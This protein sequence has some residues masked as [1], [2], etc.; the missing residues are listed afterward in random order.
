MEKALSSLP[1]YENPP[2]S[3]VV[4][5][6]QFKELAKLQVPHIG[7]FWERIGRVEFPE[8]QE[9]PPLPHIVEDYDKLPHRSAI[10]SIEKFDRPPLPRIFFISKEKNRLIQVQ[11][12]RLLQN[13]RKLE[14]GAEYPRY[15]CLFPQ[16]VEL[17]RVF[18]DFV[19][20]LSVGSLEPDQY[21]LTYVN[22]IA[23]GDGWEDWRD[24]ERIF[25]DIQ[26]KVE[27]HFLPVPQEITWHR[28]YGFPND[29]GRLHVFMQHALAQE[30]KQEVLVLNLTARG[31]SSNDMGGWFDMAH[32]WIVRGFTDLTGPEIQ[33]SIWKRKR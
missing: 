2:V 33:K 8:C 22:H 15:D 10:L 14:V 29:S 30:M 16:F 13:W 7:A 11:R 3:E 20:G 32:E 24:I 26:C 1:D 19:K 12:D 23:K 18:S 27:G 6:I 4:F 31:F 21:E 5:G 25:P 28:T 9:M 17:W